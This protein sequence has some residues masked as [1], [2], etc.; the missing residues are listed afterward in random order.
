MISRRI[1]L[2]APAIVPRTSLGQSLRHVK[3]GTAF[4]TTTN[5]MSLM[6]DP[7]K[8]EGIEAEIIT[9][10]IDEAVFLADRI[11][12]FT[13]RPGQLA[14]DVYVDLPRPRDPRSEGFASLAR[15]LRAE[16]GTEGGGA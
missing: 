5:A 6:P 9:H 14:A 16:L 1:L 12:E 8:P 2:A 10:S 4:T 3:L 11:L 13:P 7:L 15:R